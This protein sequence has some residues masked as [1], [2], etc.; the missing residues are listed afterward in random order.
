M[1]G[2]ILPCINRFCNITFRLSRNASKTH[3][4]SEKDGAILSICR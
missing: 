2:R 1:D 4:N 3:G